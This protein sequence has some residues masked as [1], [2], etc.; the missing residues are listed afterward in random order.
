MVHLLV[1]ALKEG[2][3]PSFHGV[4]V[5]HRGIAYRM[6]RCILTFGYYFGVI[7]FDVFG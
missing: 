4:V 2:V 1:I 5:Y 7:T 3:L 6:E